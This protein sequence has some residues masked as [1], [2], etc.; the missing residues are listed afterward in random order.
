VAHD[1]QDAYAPRRAALDARFAALPPAGTTAWW[2]AIERTD[3]PDA[4]PYEVLAR[5][6]RARPAADDTERVLTAILL[7]IGPSVRRWAAVT[8]AKAPSGQR[9]ELAKDL[10]QECYLKLWQELE[11]PEKRFIVE[12]FGGALMRLQQHTAH[13]LM[14]KAGEWT[15]PGVARPQ[16][17]PT[18]QTERL[19]AEPEADG[20]LP[21]GATLA[22]RRAQD[23][24]DRVELSDL[25]DLVRRLPEDKR[26]IIEEIYW[27]HRTQA[28]AA[29]AHG[30]T[31]RT[32]RN[33][34]AAALR[35]LKIRYRGGEEDDRG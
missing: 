33:W 29:A 35:E 4:L 32:V 34:L 18:G 12:N 23:D 30:V 16:R 25:L 3:G 15:R 11:N 2:G 17:V 9:G 13:D 14:L 22:D 28:E 10:E 31:E 19:Q 27:Q 8:A 26:A 6:Y 21:L 1:Q 5:C 7:R 24:L 20:T